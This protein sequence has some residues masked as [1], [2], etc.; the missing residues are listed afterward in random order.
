MKLII[1]GELTDLNTY[2]NK[3]RSNRFF[4]AKVKKRET[5][6]V[7]MECLVQKIHPISGPVYIKYLWFCKNKRKDKS[8]VSFAK[9]FIEDGLIS[10]H[11]LENDGWDDIVGFRDDF[12]IDQN[13]PRVEIDI[14]SIGL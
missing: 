4:G 14:I 2:I 13:N 9:K 10:A 8:N 1:P 3:E 6:R 11:V 12:F 5:E 7:A